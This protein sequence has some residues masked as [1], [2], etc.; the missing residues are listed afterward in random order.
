MDYANNIILVPSFVSILTINFHAW[1]IQQLV[2]ESL[3][4]L[5]KNPLLRWIVIWECGHTAQD[6]RRSC[7]R[8]SFTADVGGSFLIDSSFTLSFCVVLAGGHEVSWK[9]ELQARPIKSED[10]M[11]SCP[12]SCMPVRMVIRKYKLRI[13]AFI[14]SVGIFIVVKQYV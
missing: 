14:T 2:E 3:P 6:V 4:Y 1:S 8:K 13:D 5:L 7:P 11:G 10:E 12:F 9:K